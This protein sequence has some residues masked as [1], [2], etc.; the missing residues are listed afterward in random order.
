MQCKTEN[1]KTFDFQETNFSKKALEGKKSPTTHNRI[2]II[3]KKLPQ[4][5]FSKSF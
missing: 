4:R 2:L 5:Y 3:A 1:T